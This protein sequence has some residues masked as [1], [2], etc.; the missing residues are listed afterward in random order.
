MP[1]VIDGT[2]GIDT[3]QVN[4]AS[5]NITALNSTISTLLARNI[6]ETINAT[7]TAA[8]GNVT[9]NT[10]TQTVLY[11]TTNASANFGVAITGNSTVT[12]N[13]LLANGQTVSLAFLNSNGITPYYAND[14]FI[15]GSR[16]APYWQG[17]SAP[18][19]GNAN[20][21]DLYTYTVIKTAPSTFTVLAS[22]SRYANT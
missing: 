10:L 1:V 16:V 2:T 19:Q 9:F 12:L 21:I 20:S 22:Q 15:D 11:Y 18:V 8:T 14:T 13:S 7:A 4:A 17:G 6:Y 3:P 5:F